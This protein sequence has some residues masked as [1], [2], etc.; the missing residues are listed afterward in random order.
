MHAL[1]D[2]LIFREENLQTRVL[3][4]MDQIHNSC[5]AF[6][7]HLLPLKQFIGPFLARKKLK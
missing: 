2:A 6:I 1:I 4:V 5:S 7:S 3:K